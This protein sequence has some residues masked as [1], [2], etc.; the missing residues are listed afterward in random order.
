MNKSS[1]RSERKF[2]NRLFDIKNSQLSIIGCNSGTSCDGLDLALAA[3]SRNKLPR[4]LFSETY[5][6]PKKIRDS[7]LAA[8]EPGFVD[9]ERW[10]ALDSELGQ[11]MGKYLVDFIIALKRKK[12]P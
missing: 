2:L 3:F 6:Y 1:G 9:G 12:Y 11:L 5:K 8:G 10:M 7:L 4:L